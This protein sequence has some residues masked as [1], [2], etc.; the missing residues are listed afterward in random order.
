MAS[1]T[2]T[3]HIEPCGGEDNF[4]HVA[5]ARG[6]IYRCSRECAYAPQKSSK[7]KSW[8]PDPFMASPNTVRRWLYE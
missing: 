7:P 4:C 2:N 1:S 6:E 8:R 3:A 5:E